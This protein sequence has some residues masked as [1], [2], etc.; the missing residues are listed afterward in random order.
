MTTITYNQRVTDAEAA[1]DRVVDARASELV[2]PDF[3]NLNAPVLARRYGLVAAFST[4]VNAL[5]AVGNV[6]YAFTL[7]SGQ[8]NLRVVDLLSNPIAYTETIA[9]PTVT[10]EPRAA[11]VAPDGDF[12]LV[13]TTRIYK[14][15][16]S[17][18]APR[19]ASVRNLAAIPTN[20]IDSLITLGQRMFA[21]ARTSGDIWDFNP[22]DGATTNERDYPSHI[23][24]DQA[25]KAAFVYNNLVYHCG[26]DGILWRIRDIYNDPIA[27]EKYVATMPV[28][29]NPQGAAV[30]SDGN[31]YLMLGSRNLYRINPRTGATTSQY[32]DA[33]HEAYPFIAQG[34]NAF[35][36]PY[37]VGREVDRVNAIRNA[38]RMNRL[39]GTRS[40]ID[41]FASQ[42]GFSYTHLITSRTASVTA[43]VNF[44]IT[45]P[46]VA[47]LPVADRANWL[48][49]VKGRLARMLPAY[50]ELGNVVA[51]A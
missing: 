8:A 6:L 26:N 1:L 48:E 23:D 43:K 32:A 3:Y 31:A 22:S 36:Y 2:P 38:I 42:M 33:I 9:L 41:L 12:I 16:V 37:G 44:N 21:F 4:D 45:Y 13:T 40:G 27:T 50:Y 39:R 24:G 7:D 35:T 25:G 15:T 34:L 30:T 5:A 51:S 47:T 49:W 28:A 20:G 19:T 10:T 17:D 11:A 29:D 18:G 46:A 14:V